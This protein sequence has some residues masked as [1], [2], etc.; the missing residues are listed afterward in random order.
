[1]PNIEHFPKLKTLRASLET[2]DITIESVYDTINACPNLKRIDLESLFCDEQQVLDLIRSHPHFR[3]D[4]PFGELFDDDDD[5][6]N[7]ALIDVYNQH[8][9]S[10]SRLQDAVFS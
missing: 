9:P 3:F 4:D 8:F 6:L 10:F 7:P 2:I 5:Y 1:M